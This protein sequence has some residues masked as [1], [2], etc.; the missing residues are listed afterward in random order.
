MGNLRF[1]YLYSHPPLGDSPTQKSGV[2]PDKDFAFA[3]LQPSSPSEN[4]RLFRTRFMAAREL[5]A[6]DEN[7]PN[8]DAAISQFAA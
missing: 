2:L 6:D 5:V 7:T 1:V 8:T 4:A 3:A